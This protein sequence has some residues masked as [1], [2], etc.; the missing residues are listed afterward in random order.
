M[1]ELTPTT[2]VTLAKDQYM[3]IMDK[4]GTTLIAFV[5]PA[6]GVHVGH[7]VEQLQAK[8]VNAVINV[9]DTTE[10]TFEL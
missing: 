3:A 8:G 7:L 4:S 1:K 10:R 6:K 9:R 5:T 2:Q